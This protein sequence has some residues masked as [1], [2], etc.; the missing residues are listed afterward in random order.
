LPSVASAAASAVTPRTTVTTL[1]PRPFDSRLTRTTPS[2][3]GGA[4]DCDAQTQLAIGCRQAGHI[5]PPSVEYTSPPVPVLPM[6]D[7]FSFVGL[8]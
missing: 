2:P 4:A 5:R 8:S 7:A 6:R 3:R 1:P